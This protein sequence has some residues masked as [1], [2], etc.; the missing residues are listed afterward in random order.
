MKFNVYAIITIG[1]RCTHTAPRL[2]TRFCMEYTDTRTLVLH[3]IS[4]ILVGPIHKVVSA[5]STRHTRIEHRIHNKAQQSSRAMCVRES[6]DCAHTSIRF[7]FISNKSNNNNNS[8][9][10]TSGNR[11]S[12]SETE[13]ETEKNSNGIKWKC[14]VE[15]KRDAPFYNVTSCCCWNL[16]SSFGQRK[17]RSGRHRC[18]AIAVVH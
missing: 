15:H 14:I 9:I 11:I 3:S 8:E 18:A 2:H 5:D 12:F 4:F 17:I 1:M 16:F 7:L 6:M 13:R 10:G